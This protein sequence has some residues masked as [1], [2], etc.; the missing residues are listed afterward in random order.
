MDIFE[1]KEEAANTSLIRLQDGS[2]GRRY[3]VIYEGQPIG[4]VEQTYP[5]IERS[6]KGSRILASRTK[7]KTAKWRYSINGHRSRTN[8]DT[9]IAAIGWLIYKV[10]NA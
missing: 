6:I 7:S 2:E 9:R 5:M 1:A 3:E 10:T 8:E 4:I